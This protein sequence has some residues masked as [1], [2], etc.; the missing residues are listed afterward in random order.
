MEAVVWENFLCGYC[1]FEENLITDQ[2]TCLK[3]DLQRLV[4]RYITNKFRN[5]AFI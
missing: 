2:I 5:V 3:K 4:C 1:K